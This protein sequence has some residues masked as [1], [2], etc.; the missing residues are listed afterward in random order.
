MLAP[1]VIASANDMTAIPGDTRTFTCTFIGH[2]I[3][4]WVVSGG[5][6]PVTITQGNT[7]SF[8]TMP[9]VPPIVDSG[10]VAQL[11]VSVHLSLNGTM[12]VC[13]IDIAGGTTVASDPAKL[14]VFGRYCTEQQLQVH[15]H[16]PFL[17][18]ML[19]LVCTPFVYLPALTYP[20][21]YIPTHN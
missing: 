10:T 8:F 5:D 9:N 3:P 4:Y 13:H 16:E 18:E 14:T 19:Y 11:E 15:M 20:H 1:M 17:G 2:T 7:V 12:Y 21:S 6:S